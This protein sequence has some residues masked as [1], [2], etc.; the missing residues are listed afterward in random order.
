MRRTQEIEE[1]Y[2]YK[3]FASA[4]G[5][6]TEYEVKDKPDIRITHD[7]K[8]IGLEITT[9]HLKDGDDIYYY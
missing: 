5:L 1:E 9:F 6:P 8:K 3:G 4:F 2:Y 7:N